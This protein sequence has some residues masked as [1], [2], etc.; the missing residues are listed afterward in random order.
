MLLSVLLLISCSHYV[1]NKEGYIRPPK[2]YKFSY[3]R[4]LTKLT[5]NK[6]IDTTAIYYLHN[7]DYDRKNSGYKNKDEYIRFYSDGIFKMQR[8]EEYPKIE[9]INNVNKGVVGY[10]KLKGKV[11]KLQIYGD[12]DGGSDQLEFGLIND[13]GNLIILNENPRSTFYIGYSEKIIKRKIEKTSYLNP[14]KYE[15]VKIKGLT[16]EKLNW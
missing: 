14:K 12:I 6:I 8:T 1:I 10:Y 5:G 15:K 11:I 13:N 4:N 3:S 16:Y 9:D 7:S 2:N